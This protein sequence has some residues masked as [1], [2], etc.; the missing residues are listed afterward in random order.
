ML[1]WLDAT[2]PALGDGFI[3]AWTASTS[4]IKTD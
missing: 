1:S 2:L 3:R 4:A